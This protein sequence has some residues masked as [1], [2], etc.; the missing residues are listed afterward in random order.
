MSKLSVYLKDSPVIPLFKSYLSARRQAVYVHGTH[1]EE[2]VLKFGVPQGSILGPVLF[3]IYI[4]DLPQNLPLDLVECHMLADDTTLHATGKDISSIE[5]VLQTAADKVSQWCTNNRMLINPS[6]TKSMVLT[7]RQKH[8]LTNLNINLSLNDQAI[9]QVHEHRLLGVLVDDKISW[10]PHV[11]DLC[12]KISKKVY[13]LSK[14]QQFIDTDTRKLFFNAHIKSHID[15]A[16]IVWDGCSEA[17]L[18]RVNS[19]YRRAAKK[20]LPD[21]TIS[22]DQKMAKIGMPSLQKHFAFNK[23]IH[24]HKIAHNKAPSYLLGLFTPLQS[25]HTRSNERLMVPRPRVDI[26]KSSFSFSG[27]SLWNSLPPQIKHCTSLSSF[28]KYTRAY[29]LA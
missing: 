27:A 4:N 11:N 2:G 9:E 1:S 5:C 29:M 18:K 21:P 25:R 23:A 28:K 3:C 10:Q 19:L 26:F 22:T 6:K 17:C 7:T 24:M 13:L 12:K 14:L 15:Y 20:I 8:Q 16:S